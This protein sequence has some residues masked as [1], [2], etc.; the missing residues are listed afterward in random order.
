M[1]TI[2]ICAAA[3]L[4]AAVAQGAEVPRTLTDPYLQIQSA[5]V[6]DKTEGIAD[7][8]TALQA[9]AATLGQEAEKIVATAK[10][11]EGAKDIAAARS[12]F[13][14][15]SEALVNY[16]DKTKSEF[17]DLRVAYCPMVNKP[18]VQK[19]KEIKNPYYGSAMSTCGS[20][21]K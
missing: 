6:N 16:A 10:K 8:A 21:K 1:K 3:V 18:W 5:L 12:A 11:L 17:G 13:G 20:F 9:A 14:D 7:S 19:E 2:L 15:V 4:A